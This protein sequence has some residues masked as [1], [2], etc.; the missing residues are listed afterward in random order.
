PS[1]WSDRDGH[2]ANAAAGDVCW[3]EDLPVVAGCAPVDHAAAFAASVKNITKMGLSF[4][5]GNNFAFGAGVNEP[6]TATFVMY[7]F[8]VK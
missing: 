7:N 6:A 3:V 1:Q 2:M 8:S 5:G 4:G